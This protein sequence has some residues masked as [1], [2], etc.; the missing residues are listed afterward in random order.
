MDEDLGRLLSNPFQA[1]PGVTKPATSAEDDTP[2]DF[3]DLTGRSIRDH[4]AFRKPAPIVLRPHV[5][6]AE[7]LMKRLTNA[8]VPPAA[9]SV[10]DQHVP[11]IRQ[12]VESLKKRFRVFVDTAADEVLEKEASRLERRYFSGTAS[13]GQLQFL[14]L[15]RY[16]E[17]IRTFQEF[18]K[19][20]WRELHKIIDT[21]SL[22]PETRTIAREVEV[23]YLKGV[24]L[25]LRQTDSF[26]DSLKI[27]MRVE[28]EE[29]DSVTGGTKL[30]L[31]YDP[32][33]H[34]SIPAFLGDPVE[35]E[36]ALDEA[37][38]SPSQMEETAPKD[39]GG[40]IARSIVLETKERRLNRASILSAPLL[41]SRDW[42]RTLDYALEIPVKFY[43]ECMENFRKAYHVNIGAEIL[44]QPM[45]SAAALVRKGA[46]EGLVKE[47]EQFILRSLEDIIAAVLRTDFPGTDKP[48]VFI[49]HCG[50]QVIYNILIQ[51]LRQA[52]MAEIFYLDRNNTT[53]RE[54]PEE[55]I[56][57]IVID[58]WESTFTPLHREDVDSYLT[59]SRTIEMVKRDYRVLNDE[60]AKQAKKALPTASYAQREKWLRENQARIFGIRKLEIFRRFLGAAE[61]S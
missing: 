23:E 56:K 5:A 32:H 31:T 14:K 38:E 53:V 58:W 2:L 12:S 10:I 50:P 11:R 6:S 1:T 20:D 24:H 49:Y 55:L 54:L 3:G 27:Y 41:G 44:T 47:Y 60:G 16:Y 35:N 19:A 33:V 37:V 28:H 29:T 21:L 34:Y 36:H 59:Y 57:K 22:I 30:N 51:V 45:S 13:H 40:S 4:S 7:Y 15:K 43:E 8:T 9:K 39:D 48:F 61:F 25:L 42:N 17:K 18:A 26:L 46:G 52:K